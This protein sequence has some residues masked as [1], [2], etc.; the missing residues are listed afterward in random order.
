MKLTFY[1]LSLGMSSC[2]G[3]G[4]CIIQSD[5]D[6]DIYI[7]TVCP[8]NCQLVNCHNYRYCG[9]KRPQW[10]LNCDGG[11]CK[12]CAVMIGRLTF[13]DEV[14]ECPICMESKNM[15]QISCGRHTLCLEC[16]LHMSESTSSYPVKCPLCRQGIWR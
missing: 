16:W 14:D 15:V 9:Q 3:D 13:M 12:D 8:H 1:F 10:V 5:Y 2:K 6:P 11:M 4:S 7:Y